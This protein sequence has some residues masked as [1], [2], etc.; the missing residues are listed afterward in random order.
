MDEARKIVHAKKP[1]EQ[2]LNKL[3]NSYY[4]NIPH[5]FGYT[6][7]D[8][9]AL[10]LDSDVKIDKAFD[11]L[12]VLNQAKD[13]EA[14][15]SKKSAI[16]SQYSTLNADLEYV[17]PSEATWKWLETMVLE[18]RASNHSGLGKLKVHKIFRV[19]RNQEHENFLASAERIAK[20]C[21]KWDPSPIYSSLVKKR[22]DIPKDLQD[23]LLFPSFC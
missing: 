14:V 2:E 5:N 16:D 21:G 19:K 15:I 8:A 10:R 9:N 11:M 18:T 12:D 6:R 1:D 20:E 7:I 17:D 4:S 3:T 13:V 22:P 23:L